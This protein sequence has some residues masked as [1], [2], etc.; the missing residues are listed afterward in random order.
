MF[1]L[2]TDF[3]QPNN[4]QDIFN[5]TRCLIFSVQPFDPFMNFLFRFMRISVSSDRGT[6][7]VN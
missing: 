3:I 7:D 2:F 6:V 5:S 4:R 1:L